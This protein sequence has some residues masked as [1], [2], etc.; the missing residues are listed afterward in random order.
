MRELAARIYRSAIAL[1]L[2]RTSR[3]VL[4]RRLTYLPPQKLRSLERLVAGIEADRID[5]TVVE[6]GVALGGSAIVLAK[7]SGRP[8]DGYDVFGAMPEPGAKDPGSVH[9]RYREVAS[10][11]A[12]GIG[13]DRYYGYVP[14]L[15]AA[16]ERAFDEAGVPVGGQVRLHEGRFDQTLHPTGPVAL[17]HIDCDRHDPVALCLHRLWPV[18]GPGGSIVLD[19]YTGEGGCRAAADA[20]LASHPDAA[21]VA[22]R[23]HGIIRKR[24]A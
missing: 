2:S 11:R 4:E 12:K 15:L 23:P 3:D 14:D 20:F 9:D 5:G 21:L 16:V 10:G 24:V 19:D 1:R 22:T 17:A 13:G 8:F 7:L 18:M 6:C